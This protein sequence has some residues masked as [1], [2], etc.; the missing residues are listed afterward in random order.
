MTSG[1]NN[2]SNFPVNQLTKFRALRLQKKLLPQLF[3]GSTVL[4]RVNGVDVRGRS[5]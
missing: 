1:G 5:D 4:P 3:P 2:F